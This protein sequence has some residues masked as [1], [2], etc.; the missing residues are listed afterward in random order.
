MNVLRDHGLSIALAVLYVAFKVGS[1]FTTPDDPF[2]YA[3][4]HGHS[5]DT[6]GALLIVLGTK[7]WRERGS[8]ASK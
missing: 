1:W 5:D 8:A 6:F 7:W 3:T 2:W 4:L